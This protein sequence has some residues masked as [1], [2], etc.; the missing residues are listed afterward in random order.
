MRTGA[1]LRA[2]KSASVR[3]G[4][5]FTLRSARGIFVDVHAAAEN[6]F[7]YFAAKRRNSARLFRQTNLLLDVADAVVAVNKAA[8][9]FEA[10]GGLLRR[11]GEALLHLLE[12]VFRT[13]EHGVGRAALPAGGLEVAE[14]EA[15]KLELGLDALG[16]VLIPAE[17][18]K[19]LALSALGGVF[20]RGGE[21]GQ[22]FRGGFFPSEKR[23]LSPFLC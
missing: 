11:L 10:G 1:S 4:R 8:E 23:C 20:A 21:G 6:D 16:E 22:S 19:Q 5:F 12:H 15:H 2:K 3:T 13:H 17:L 14:V 18:R 7:N 9:V